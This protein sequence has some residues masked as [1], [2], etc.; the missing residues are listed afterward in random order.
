MGGAAL[1]ALRAE[2][3][4]TVAAAR[5]SG[6]PDGLSDAV[7][8]ALA[9]VEALT[10]ELAARGQSGDVDGMLLHSSDYLELFSV[11]VIG[12]QHLALAAAALARQPLD[13]DDAAFRRGKLLGAQYFIRTEVPRLHY[14]AALCRSGED[15]YSRIRAAEL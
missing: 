12:W 7:L 5:R 6:V 14:L 11:L 13:E 10:L 1:A 3:E 9:E 4:A 2:I 8:G 15:S